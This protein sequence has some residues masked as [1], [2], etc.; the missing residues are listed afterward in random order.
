MTGGPL[1]RDSMND[2]STWILAFEERLT[3]RRGRWPSA[4]GFY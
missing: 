1:N 2:D 3:S 4:L